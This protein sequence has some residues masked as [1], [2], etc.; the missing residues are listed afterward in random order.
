MDENEIVETVCG[1]LQ[2]KG[3]EISQ[4]LHTTEHGV[5]IVAKNRTSDEIIHIEA[6]GGTSSRIGSARFGKPYS[7]PQVFDRV[8]KGFYTVCQMLSQNKNANS[9]FALAVPDTILFRKYLGAVKPAMSKL[10]ISVLLV[11][12]TQE[13]SEF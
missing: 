12:Q 11:S 13:V 6:K 1:Y 3:Y 7:P 8:A 9:K 10:G 2:K 5:D 4:K